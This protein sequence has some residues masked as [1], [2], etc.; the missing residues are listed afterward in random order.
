MKPQTKKEK[1]Y[2]RMAMEK[3]RSDVKQFMEGNTKGL[4][5]LGEYPR[6]MEE[7]VRTI[8]A[9]QDLLDKSME[10]HARATEHLMTTK[11]ERDVLTESTAFLFQETTA[12]SMSYSH[13]MEQALEK[14]QNL[15]K[16]N[17]RITAVSDDLYM[18]NLD[19]N[20]KLQRCRELMDAHKMVL[21]SDLNEKDLG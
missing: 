9:L 7:A 16:E 21:K 12:I 17:K 1:E 13:K 8:I 2:N 3:V 6:T 20:L 11:A 4:A 10:K 18:K 14:I 15:E 19:I 5:H